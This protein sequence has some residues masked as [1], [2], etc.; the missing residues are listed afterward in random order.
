M[1]RPERRRREAW[2]CPNGHDGWPRNTVTIRGRRHVDLWCDRCDARWEAN[3]E[4]RE[5]LIASLTRRAR[6]LPRRRD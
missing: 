4:Q 6:D 2:T 3:D 5:I 1:T